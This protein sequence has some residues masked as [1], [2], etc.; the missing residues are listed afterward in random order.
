[1]SK[2]M[3]GYLSDKDYDFI[4]SKSTRVCVDL[5]LEEAKEVFLIKRD[6]QPYEG[7][8]HLPGGRIR[9]R[10]NINAA[11][12]RIAKDEMNIRVYVPKLIGFMEF[13]REEQNGKKRHTVSLVFMVSTNQIPKN[14]KF[15]DKL[16]TK[17]IPVHMRFLKRNKII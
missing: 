8:W 5:V 4:Y 1:M 9:F 7:N 14:G 16:P 10:E 6:I 11:I 13:L 17:T 15:F 3:K 2:N 12:T